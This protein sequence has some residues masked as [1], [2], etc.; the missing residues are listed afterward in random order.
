MELC[1][2]I[3]F[4]RT[5]QK[6]H[7]RVYTTSNPSPA[8][9]IANPSAYYPSGRKICRTVA[10]GAAA[11]REGKLL[12]SPLVSLG[13]SSEQTR[14]ITPSHHA[15]RTRVP[16]T[17]TLADRRRVK[18]AYTSYVKRKAW[19]FRHAYQTRD[20]KSKTPPRRDV[21]F[22]AADF[23]ST[24]AKSDDQYQRLVIAKSINRKT[25]GQKLVK[26]LLRFS[27]FC[28]TSKR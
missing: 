8:Y 26:I 28:A 18:R 16:D 3:I 6:N 4:H 22:A 11:V 2:Q 7:E 5:P 25:F 12:H 13:G 23:Q 9:I 24:A 10:G 20:A 19:D 1:Y 27:H 17:E 14:T 21:M 15:K